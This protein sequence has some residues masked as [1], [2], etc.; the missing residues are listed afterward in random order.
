LLSED[1][2]EVV[3]IDCSIVSI[4]SF[5]ID[6]LLSSESI[7]FGVKMTKIKPDNKIELREILGLPCL[8]LDQHLSSRK[9]LKVFIIYN[10]INRLDLLGSVT[11]F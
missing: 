5:R 11:K 9:V 8:P 7:Q 3:K 4:L 2:F 6:V 10:N 1:G